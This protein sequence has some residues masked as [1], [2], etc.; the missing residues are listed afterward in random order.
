MVYLYVEAIAPSTA[1]VVHM[2]PKF[3]VSIAASVVLLS[4]GT[5][6]LIWPAK[7]Q[8]YMLKSH[9]VSEYNPFFG[10]MKTK[11]YILSLRVTGIIALLMGLVVL[12]GLCVGRVD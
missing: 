3:A 1:L 11:G 7:I 9:S 4:L 5:V 12:W 8:Q 2:N 10:W 6:S